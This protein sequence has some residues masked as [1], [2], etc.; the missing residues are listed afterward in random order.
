M[1]KRLGEELTDKVKQDIAESE[2]VNFFWSVVC[3]DWE[4]ESATALLQM[5]VNQYIKIRGF[6]LANKLVEEFKAANKRTTQKSKGIRKQL[7]AQPSSE[8]TDK[9]TTSS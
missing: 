8:E 6:S 7:V 2:E 3:G 4:D 5:I 9:P 1:K